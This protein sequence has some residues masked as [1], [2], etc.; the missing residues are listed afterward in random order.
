MPAY[1]TAIPAKVSLHH[2]PKQIIVTLNL[3]NIGKFN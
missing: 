3:S 1:I 2:F